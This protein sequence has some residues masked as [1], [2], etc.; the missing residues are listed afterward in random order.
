MLDVLSQKPGGAD[1][2]AVCSERAEEEVPVFIQEG[3]GNL[4]GGRVRERGAEWGWDGGGNVCCF[5]LTD[6]WDWGS[7]AFLKGQGPEKRTE[8]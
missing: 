3:P 6:E 2:E 4:Q 5:V 7:R 1:L 8:G